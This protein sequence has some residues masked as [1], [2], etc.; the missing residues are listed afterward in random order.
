VIEAGKTVGLEYTLSLEDGSVVQS[1]TGGEP[2]EY[3]HGE[4]QILPALE[5]ELTGLAVNEEKTVELRAEKAYGEIDPEAFQEVDI[6]KIPEAARKV[7]AELRAEGYNGSI[8]VAEVKEGT[9]VLDFNHPL[10]GEDL[11]FNVKV[12]SIE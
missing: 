9:A 11:V 2:L 10:A 7:G 6:D 5:E 8:R 3:V 12:L 1:N 4:H